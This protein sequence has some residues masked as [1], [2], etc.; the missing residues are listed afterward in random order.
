M[1]THFAALAAPRRWRQFGGLSLLCCALLGLTPIAL[2]KQA[3]TNFLIDARQLSGALIQFSRQSGKAI[4][5][6]ERLARQ[7]R[8]SPVTGWMSPEAALDNLLEDSGLAWEEVEPQVIAV[9]PAVCRA[10]RDCEEPQQTLSKYP[11][12]QPGIEETYVYGDLVTGSRIR[13]ADYHGA[14]PVDIITAPDIE[15]SGAQT[16]GELLKF[17]P[18]VAGNSISTAISN[19]GDGTA[20]VTL[21]GLPASNT[22][23][24]INGRRVANDGLAG[25]SVDLNSIA[26]AAVERI[27][28]LKGGASAIYGSDAIAGVVN[29]IM[30]RE[31]TGLLA[32]LYYGEAE[33]GDLETTNHTLQYG[34]NLPRTSLF[35]TATHF[36][37]EPLYS[38][39]RRISASA[40][41]RRFGGSDERSSATPAARIQLPGGDT[42]IAG[43]NGYRPATEED[44]YD[45]QQGTT[46]V[47]P[48]ERNSVYANLA[49]DVSERIVAL[50][51]LHYLETKAI[52][53]LA[54]APVFTAFEAR[55]FTISADNRFNPFGVDLEDVRRRLVEFPRRK[56]HN[57][58]EVSRASLALEGLAADWNWELAYSWSRSEAIER[59][60]NLVNADHLRRGLGPDSACRGR[61]IDGCVPINLLG[62]PGSIT[63]QQVSYLRV[64][65][66]VAGYS[67]LSTVS[68]HVSRAILPM[69]GGT[70]DLA[71]GGEHR[72]EAT[73]KKP[74]ALLASTGTLGGTNFEA[75]RGDRKIT[76][77][78]AEAR[79]PMWRSAGGGNGLDLDLA[80]RYS[81]Y[82][83]FGDSTNPRAALRLQ[84]G[85]EWLL[86]GNF[87]RGFR[88]PSLNELYEGQT[89]NQAFLNDPCTQAH[90][91][92]LLPGCTQQA[93]PTRNQF[94]TLKGGNAELEPET[95]HSVS[96]G[97]VWSP[98]SA[99]GLT[100]SMDLFQIDQY[101]VV[102]SSAQYIVSQNARFGAFAGQVERDAAGN[103]T[104]VEAT[105]VNVGRRRVRG[106]DLAFNYHLPRRSWGQLSFTGTGAY[107]A[108]YLAR[109][110]ASGPELDL[111]GSFRDEASEGLGGIPEWK[112]RLGMRWKHRRWLGSYDLFYVSEMEE[113]V[114]GTDRFRTIDSWLVHDLQVSYTFP[115][116]AGLR[117]A[118]GV[119]NLLDEEPPLAASAFNDNIDGRTHELKGRFWYTR[120][121]QSF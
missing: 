118:V 75:T 79:L 110:D 24:L 32:E 120:L 47:V 77:L 65:G 90:N 41:T 111:A 99:S 31:F 17:V 27:E 89:E 29:V 121:S 98:E 97:V 9:Y 85:R 8:V 107:I 43:D 45:F 22:L 92:A 12:F 34:A 104:L 3:T 115:V 67:S 28:I 16:L 63:P 96:A 88:A 59:T 86:R 100:L 10:G 19:G 72:L 105:N 39:D 68:A 57:E 25:E 23:V 116:L 7:V 54:P 106:A 64:D 11:T 83:D 117:W 50:L 55:P 20:T 119:D 62:G 82:S 49:F 52:A 112:A 66:E 51:D 60:T 2:G 5:F 61:D 33:A 78:Y 36:E 40:D 81:D 91:V 114:P 87:A 30:K 94:L 14:I 38:R 103:L 76:E 102:S 70:G 101:D 93:D 4:V 42:L 6:S 84:L 13:R 1:F 46:A 26:P 44:L 35:V 15:L 37:Q 58:S 95:A 21:R 56:Q 80:L 108:E 71:L 69:P 74:D 73:S 109:N 113:L 48:M 18:A 53:E